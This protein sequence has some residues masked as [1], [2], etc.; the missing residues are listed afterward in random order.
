M[1]SRSQYKHEVK[2]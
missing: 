2:W 1:S